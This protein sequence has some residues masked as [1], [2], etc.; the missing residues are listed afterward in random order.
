ME[1]LI[2]IVVFVGVIYV[3]GLVLSFKAKAQ[4]DLVI[5]A[6]PGAIAST[7]EGHF[8]KVWW[9]TTRG[10]GAFNYRPRGL[11]LGGGVIKKKPVLSISLE[12]TPD[13]ATA[14]QAW[15]SEW[16]QGSGIVGLADRVVFKRSGLF[17]KLRALEA[18]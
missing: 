7:I 13:G 10:D 11:G 15:M 14:V 8:T 17:R 18:S 4:Q 1:I 12:P 2:G 5:R 9:P 6:D 3:F 16:G